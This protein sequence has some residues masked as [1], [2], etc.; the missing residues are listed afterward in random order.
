MMELIFVIIV[1]GIL[2][3]VFIPR[4]GQNNLSQAANQLISHIRYTQHLALMDDKY[5]PDVQYWYKQR[6]QISFS[7][8]NSTLSYMIFSDSPSLLTGAY[9]GNPGANVTYTD[10]EVATNPLNKTNYLIG[11]SYASFANSDTSR[12]TSNL[13]LQ[14][15][16]G[17]VDLKVTGG[18]SSTA[19]NISF[20]HLGRPYLGVIEN[21]ISPQ[22]HLA[23]GQIYIKL[24]TTTCTGSNSTANSN[25][26]AVI[27]I[28]PETGYVHLL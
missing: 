13:D 25:S 28:E 24:C 18:N 8:A 26:E 20:D 1:I 11:T 16:Y 14:K 3:A 12:L 21:F 23:T 27:V 2:S 7:T 10:V 5:D 19:K 22:D 6:W 4:F 15:K 17:I 9:D